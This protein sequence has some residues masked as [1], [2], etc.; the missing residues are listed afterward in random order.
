MW[1]TDDM[2]PVSKETEQRVLDVAK[3]FEKAGSTVAYDA[4]PDFDI[5]KSHITY[6]NLLTAVMSS[7]QPESFVEETEEKFRALRQ[8]IKALRQ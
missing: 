5:K 7:A 8:A 6:Q 2:S 1:A 4:R 3:C